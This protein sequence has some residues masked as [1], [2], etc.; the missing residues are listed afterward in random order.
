MQRVTVTYPNKS[1]AKFDFDYY[2]K[3]H[4]PFVAGLVGK[5]IEVR[6]GISTATG[7][8][9]AFVCM[10]TIPIDSVAAFQTIFS[11][12]GA[13]ILADIPNYTNIEPIVQF[14]EILA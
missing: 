10:A 6:R 5:S 9:A 14:D 12:H 2:M 8:P 3:K 11:Q 13:E 7:S 1:D 4:I